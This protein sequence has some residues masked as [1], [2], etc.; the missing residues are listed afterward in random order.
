M[1]H[2]DGVRQA[3]QQTV[4]VLPK[5]VGHSQV[6]LKRHDP[7]NVETKFNLCPDREGGDHMAS[8]DSSKT[9]D[10]RSL[11]DV[12]LNCSINSEK[13]Q[14]IVSDFRI[15]DGGYTSAEPP[16]STLCMTHESDIDPTYT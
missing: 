5:T 12:V 3:G 14:Y 13:Q 7:V 11:T 16:G 4:N 2:L 1:H 6:L 9:I 15:G 10:I 8:T